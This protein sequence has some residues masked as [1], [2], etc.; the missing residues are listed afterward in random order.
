M[1][2]FSPFG[3]SSMIVRR[4]GRMEIAQDVTYPEATTRVDVASTKG[5]DGGGGRMGT[6]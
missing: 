2:G 6:A 1:M 4:L 5:L 3:L